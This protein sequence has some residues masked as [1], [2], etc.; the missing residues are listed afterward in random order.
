MIVWKSKTVGN[1][2][3]RQTEKK[4]RIFRRLTRSSIDAL[5]RWV[6]Q[7]QW[8]NNEGHRTSVDT[9]TE[10][11]TSDLKTAIDLYFP[12][13]SV[14]IHPTDKPWMTSTIKKLIIDRQQAYHSG[15]FDQ[16][17]SLRNKVRHTIYQ[18]KILRIAMHRNGGI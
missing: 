3:N 18:R 6:C 5:G 12:K 8:F 14:R 2:Q 11:F 10:S 15:H 16:W 9:M 7:H 13:K 17:K 4:K 1:R